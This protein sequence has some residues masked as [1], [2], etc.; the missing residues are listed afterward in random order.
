MGVKQVRFPTQVPESRP[1]KKLIDKSPKPKPN[2]MIHVTGPNRIK[3]SAAPPSPT[4]SCYPLE[5]HRSTDQ[6]LEDYLIILVTGL[7]G[8]GLLLGSLLLGKVSRYT[9]KAV[10]RLS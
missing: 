7:L 10:S 9:L 3:F 2:T 5:C 1:S 8:T 6:D 4:M